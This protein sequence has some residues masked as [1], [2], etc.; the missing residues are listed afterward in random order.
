MT[1]IPNSSWRSA[2]ARVFT[3]DPRSLAAL[4]IGIGILLLVNLATLLPDVRAF[5][6]DDGVLPRFARMQLTDEEQTTFPPYW[7]SLQMLDGCAAWQYTMFAL[8]AIF[9]VTLTL[10]WWTRLSTF[11]SWALL[12]GLQARNPMLFHGGDVLLRCTMFWCLFLPMG[13]C[14]SLD[15]RRRTSAP[16]P[17]CSLA[18]AGLVVQ[19]V[20]MY[21]AT[22]IVKDDPMWRVDGTALY[23][24]LQTDMFT[25]SFGRSLIDYPDV[26]HVLT[27]GT[28]VLELF[29]ALM[30]LVP[31]RDWKVRTLVVASYWGL[32]VGIAATMELGLFPYTCLVCW[33]GV[34]PTGLWDAIARR[35][36]EPAPVLPDERL[37]LPT[38]ALLV[39]LIGYLIL[40]TMTRTRHEARTP[41]P[42]PLGPLGRAAHIDQSWYLFAPRPHLFGGWYDVIGTLPDGTQVSVLE[43]GRRPRTERPDH[44]SDMWPSMA[45]RRLLLNLCEHNDCP[46]LRAGTLDYFRRVWNDKHSVDE[47]L[48]VLEVIGILNLTP[49]SGEARDPAQTC[50]WVFARWDR[51][52]GHHQPAV[53]F[54]RPPAD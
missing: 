34:L 30:L 16:G 48:S 7:V 33:L 15:A 25:T 44:G 47:Q 51:E 2:A 20:C 19:L 31:W 32:H 12:I 14:W 43:G 40:V 54:E 41:V 6:T 42:G 8:M 22:G 11:V 21:L 10:G 37:S 9:A 23:Y 52:A 50:I 24:T 5:F 45:W 29:G 26:L 13:A 46:N 53:P 4:R 17:V 49:P 27:I 28:L 36:W 38:R 1:A 3:V 35:R 18:S 39:S